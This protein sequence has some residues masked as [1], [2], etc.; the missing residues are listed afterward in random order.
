MSKFCTNCGNQVSDTA[1]FCP[2]CGSALPV[3]QPQNGYQPV[4][5]VQPT[6]PAPAS[7]PVAGLVLGIIGIVMAWLFALIGHIVSITGIA[8]SVSEYKKTGKITGLVLSIIGEA[9]A[10][11]NSVLGA[12]LVSSM[13]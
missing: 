1:T 10:I 3:N 9:C 11:I 2:Y 4:Q 5:P 6:Q 12:I 7:T 13:F 8:I